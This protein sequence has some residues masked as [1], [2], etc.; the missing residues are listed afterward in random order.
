MPAPLDLNPLASC[1]L[2]RAGVDVVVVGM[3]TAIAAAASCLT[4]VRRRCC[5]MFWECWF[6]SC[7]Q[8]STSHYHFLHAGFGGG[9][10]GRGRGRRQTVQRDDSNFTQLGGARPRRQ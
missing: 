2:W 4:R 9:V 10:F 1:P 8:G 3:A 5:L 6:P 7:S